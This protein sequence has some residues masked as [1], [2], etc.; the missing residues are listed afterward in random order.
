MEPWTAS[1]AQSDMHVTGDQKVAGSFPA[2]SGKHSF[3][4]IDQ[5]IFLRSFSLFG[6]FKKG[7]CQFLVEKCAQKHWLTTLKINPCPA[8]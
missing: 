7:I 4:E 5:E 8:E 6:W 3:A 1:V 2:G